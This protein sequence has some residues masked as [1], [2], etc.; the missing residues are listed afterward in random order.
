M[1]MFGLYFP[2]GGYTLSAQSASGTGSAIDL[3][4]SNGNFMLII[5]A[6]GGASGGASATLQMQHSHDLTA[7]TNVGA[8]LTASATGAANPFLT[9]SHSAGAYGYIRVNA[10]GVFSAAQ[11]GTGTV[12]AF[13]LPG[14]NVG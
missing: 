4:A 8:V 12:W 3:R 2:S 9:A 5:S 11:T 7:W 1:P 13:I 14:N 10:T 6:S